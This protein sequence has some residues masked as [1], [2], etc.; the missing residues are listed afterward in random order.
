MRSWER[1]AAALACLTPRDRSLLRV[2]RDLRYLTCGQAHRACYDALAP[3]GARVR[4]GELRRRGLL[5]RLRS[6]GF[7]DRRV[8]WGLAPLGRAAAAAL[9]RVEAGAAPEAAAVGTPRPDA[10]AALQMAHLIATNDLFCDVCAARRAGRLPACRWLA[11]HRSIIDL[12]HTAVV[13]DA[14]VLIAGPDGWW[15]YYLERDRG[16]MPPAAIREKLDRYALLGKMSGAQT[17]DPAWQPRV[18]AWL[19]FACDDRR[20]AHRIASLA[21][22]SGLERV[23]A[24]LA[25]ECVGGL[26]ASLGG[27]VATEPYP[28]LPAWA[29]GA[30]AVGEELA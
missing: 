14:V 4:L 6:G 26:A 27:V 10:V 29:A 2:L 1:A 22:A 19:M 5:V 3:R 13:P 7:T 20:R 11:A 23:W 24:G 17:N 25:D 9:E 16:T 8:F 28:P 18:D 30:L 12:G 15:V 21:A